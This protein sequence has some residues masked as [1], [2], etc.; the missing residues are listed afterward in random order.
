MSALLV[1]P[2]GEPDPQ[3]RE[4]RRERAHE[5]I[6]EHALAATEAIGRGEAS[7]LLLDRLAG[8]DRLG[9]SRKVLED[10]LNLDER[11]TGAAM[12]QADAFVEAA[13][14]LV[15]STPGAEAYRPGDIL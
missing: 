10:A 9:L 6:K 3:R 4:H 11:Y 7:Q 13:R 15:R 2:P 8:D 5:I 12:A 14:G 1:T